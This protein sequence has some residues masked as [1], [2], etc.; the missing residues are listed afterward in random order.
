MS[1]K[2]KVDFETNKE[3]ARANQLVKMKEEMMKD[4]EMRMRDF[5]K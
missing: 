5:K 3:R 1:S 2:Q 4:E